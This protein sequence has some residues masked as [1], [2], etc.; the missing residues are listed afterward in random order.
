MSSTPSVISSRVSGGRAGPFRSFD[1]FIRRSIYNRPAIA[2]TT[3]FTII[4]VLAPPVVAIF[5][6]PPPKP[7]D[8]DYERIIKARAE[9]S[10]LPKFMTKPNNN[11]D[12]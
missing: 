2:L 3:V 12:R 8:A 5:V 11:A 1:A 6:S 4:G 7:T 10:V 9:Y